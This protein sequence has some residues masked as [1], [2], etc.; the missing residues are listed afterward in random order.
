MNLYSLT[1]C[2]TNKIWSFEIPAEPEWVEA[3]REDGLEVDEII[4]Q[5]FVPAEGE[6]DNEICV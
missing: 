3:W 1:V 2:G 5:I 6:C 4:V